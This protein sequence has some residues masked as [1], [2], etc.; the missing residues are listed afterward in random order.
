MRLSRRPDTKD[1]R[2]SKRSFGSALSSIRSGGGNNPLPLLLPIMQKV[3]ADCKLPVEPGFRVDRDRVP[4]VEII[5]VGFL[6]WRI[7]PSL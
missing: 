6:V 2:T 4:C 7:E 5:E 1:V 3:V